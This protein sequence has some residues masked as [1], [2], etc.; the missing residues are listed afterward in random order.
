QSTLVPRVWYWLSR[1]AES[2][3]QLDVAAQQYDKLRQDE[4]WSYY[5]WLADERLAKLQARQRGAPERASVALATNAGAAHSHPPTDI[6]LPR[7]SDGGL[8]ARE[9]FS[10]ASL[11]WQLGLIDHAQRALDD[12]PIP[13]A[14][15]DAVLL[16]QLYHAASADYRAQVVIRRRFARDLED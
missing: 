14:D 8:P 7:W 16:A 4:P 11:F 2:R 1:I 3:G 10:R 12:V 5:G 6:L 13:E 15:S 9:Q